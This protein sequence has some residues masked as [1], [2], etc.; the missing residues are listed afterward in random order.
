MKLNSPDEILNLMKE[1]LNERG[2]QGICSIARNFRIIDENNSQTIDFNDF[3]QVCNMYNFGLDDNQ[4][5]IIFSNFDPENTG[6]IDYDEFIRT[7]RGEMNE[8][9]QNLVQKFLI[10]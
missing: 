10:N 2:V 1:I 3:K 8:F 5:K 7:I 9:R 6:E 4:L